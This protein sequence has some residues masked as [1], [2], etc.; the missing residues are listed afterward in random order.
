MCQVLTTSTDGKGSYA[1]AA[2]HQEVE[3]DLSVQDKNWC[4]EQYNYVLAPQLATLGWQLPGYIEFDD[5]PKQSP[6]DRVEIFIKASQ[7][8]PISQN[9]VRTELHLEEATPEEEE[10]WLQA[11]KAPAAPDPTEEETGK[12]KRPSP[13]GGGA[14]GGG[15]TKK[16]TSLSLSS[17]LTHHFGQSPWGDE[18]EARRGVELTDTD[19]LDAIVARLITEI[20]EGKVKPG[21]VDRQL[22]LSYATQ[23]FAAVELGYGKKLKDLSSGPDHKMLTALRQNIFRF[24][25]HKAFHFIREAFGQLVEDNQVKPFKQFR[26]E[27][28]SIHRDYNVNW[29]RTE[30]NV[31]V[32]NARMAS[33]EQELQANKE[34][35]PYAQVRVVQDDRTRHAKFHLVTLPVDHPFW[36]WGSPL[37]DYGCRCRKIGVVS[38]TITHNAD[39]PSKDIVPEAFQF[40]AGTDKMLFSTKHP[41]FTV[42][43]GHKGRA[44]QNFGM[45]KG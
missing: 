24:S 5:T 9:Q 29:L 3:K 4:L 6:K 44:K 18:G 11:R 17:Q 1:L 30:Y 20:H 25:S 37:Y 33:I 36:R 27:V 22:Y 13:P 39:L 35:I 41:Y 16:K 8:V 10:E 7:L 23:L 32:G 40:N 34:A 26:E 45:P 28:L 15:G 38:G 19:T 14:K 31:A 43:H 2:V 42:P 12:P 21:Q